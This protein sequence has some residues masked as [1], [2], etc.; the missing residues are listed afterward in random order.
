MIGRVATS[1]VV[2]CLM[3]LSGGCGSPQLAPTL[4]DARL[5]FQVFDRDGEDRQYM[6]YVLDRNRTL[7]GSGGFAAL[8]GDTT[9]QLPLSTDDESRLLDRMR[10][11]GWLDGVPASRV[12]DGPRQI[13]VSVRSASG[14][15]AFN[16]LA[17][18]RAFP[19]AT[20]SILADLQSISLRRLDD[21]FESLPQAGDAIQNR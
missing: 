9:W 16:M 3:I 14:A 18:G 15:H 8:Q 13:V 2:S 6:L 20:E 7:S 4:G 21:V 12:G 17:D 1:M 19:P 10:E 5:T 11:A